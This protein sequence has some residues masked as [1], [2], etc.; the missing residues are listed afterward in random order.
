[1]NRT[2][3]PRSGISVFLLTGFYKESSHLAC[4]KT[5]P[6]NFT[7]ELKFVFKDLNT[8]SKNELP[9]LL[10]FGPQPFQSCFLTFKEAYLKQWQVQALSNF[11]PF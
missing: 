5:L 2:S 8:I 10:F 6:Q 1:M 9:S 11:A 3:L 7:L 4:S